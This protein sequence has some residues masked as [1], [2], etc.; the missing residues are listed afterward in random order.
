MSNSKGK[1]VF[2]I[3]FIFLFFKLILFRKEFLTYT[4]IG[5]AAG[6]Y[7][8]RPFT[9]ARET[10]QCLHYDIYTTTES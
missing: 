9:Y 3:V 2:K 5:S 10:Q 7:A 1:I 8:T 4:Q 6:C